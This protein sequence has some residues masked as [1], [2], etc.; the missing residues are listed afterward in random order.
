M[1]ISWMVLSM[2]DG[3]IET[4]EYILVNVCAYLNGFCLIIAEINFLCW[5]LTN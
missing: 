2:Y 5:Q 1:K 3:P 4:V